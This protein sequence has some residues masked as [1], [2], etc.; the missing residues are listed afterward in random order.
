MKVL[1]QNVGCGECLQGS[2]SG[3]LNAGLIKMG[4]FAKTL[5]V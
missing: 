4:S 2:F 3:E 1:L 5:Y